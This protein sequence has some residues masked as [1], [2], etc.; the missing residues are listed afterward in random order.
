MKALIFG[1]GVLLSGAAFAAEVDPSTLYELSTQGSSQKLKAGEQGKFVLEIRVKDGAHVSD[2]APLKLA[3]SGQK[4]KPGKDKLTLADSVGKPNP[5]FEVPVTAETAGKG[6]VDAKLTF[7]ICTD[8][9]CAR[10]QKDVSVPV[11]VN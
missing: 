3:V 8:K 9:L 11:E 2:E 4:V 6:A 10:Q 5:R 1:I 7:F